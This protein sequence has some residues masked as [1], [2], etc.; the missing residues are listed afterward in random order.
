MHTNIPIFYFFEVSNSTPQTIKTYIHLEFYLFLL[1]LKFKETVS[2]LNT[3][4]IKYHSLAQRRCFKISKVSRRPKSKIGRRKNKVER[5]FLDDYQ[6]QIPFG[7]LS[8]LPLFVQISHR[9]QI[10]GRY[11]GRKKVN[12][13]AIR[14]LFLCTPFLLLKKALPEVDT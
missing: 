11:F 7:R 3:Q 4:T 5:T 1:N 12:P 8:Y 10:K 9:G 13:P 2:L 6:D 14:Q